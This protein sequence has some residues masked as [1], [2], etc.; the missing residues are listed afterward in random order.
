MTVFYSNL[1]P[2]ENTQD[3]EVGDFWISGANSF[4]ISMYDGNGWLAINSSTSTYKHIIQRNNQLKN[5]CE[6]LME[7]INEFRS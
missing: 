4:E 1:E 5:A 2:N 3:I 6:N 7:N